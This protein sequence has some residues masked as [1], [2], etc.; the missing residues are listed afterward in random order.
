[1]KLY[2]TG[3]MTGLPDMNFPAFNEA[4]DRLRAAGYEVVN[5]ADNGAGVDGMTWADYLKQDLLDMIPCDGLAYLDDWQKS[6][7]A[8]LE[9]G[10]ASTLL[11]PVKSV[12]E[13]CQPDGHLTT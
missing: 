5:P 10:V 3:P 11:M 2:V 1:M 13:W 7:G 8:R 6:K 4:S 12:S 9:I